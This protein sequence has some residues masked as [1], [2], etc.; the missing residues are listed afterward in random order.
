MDRIEGLENMSC[1]E[2]TAALSGIL[3][4]AEKDAE[5]LRAEIDKAY[6]ERDQI[7]RQ[8]E[9][10]AVKKDLDA[11]REARIRFD[12]LTEFI[13]GA[14]K[15]VDDL[16]S[17]S[18]LD[19]KDYIAIKRKMQTECFDLTVSAAEQIARALSRI[20][21]VQH[22]LDRHIARRNQALTNLAKCIHAK[23][24]NGD[25]DFSALLYKED[26]VGPYTK[27]LQSLREGRVSDVSD[28]KNA[29]FNIFYEN[30]CN[31]NS[32]PGTGA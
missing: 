32:Q 12:F 5:D 9:E 19:N 30:Y 27:N 7:G 10:A 22:S 13:G 6:A 14:E 11:Y 26:I 23:D 1:E 15:R 3:A 8:Q 29:N 21:E 16:E 4:R 25:E 28:L 20:D 2:I 17:A 24:R 31:N 18:L